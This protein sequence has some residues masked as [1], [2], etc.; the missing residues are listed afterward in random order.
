MPQLT[1]PARALTRSAFAL[2]FLLLSVAESRATVNTEAMRGLAPDAG[3]SGFTEGSL[4]LK[5]GNEDLW[6]TGLGL[7][8]QHAE[9]F[10]EAGASHGAPSGPVT[11]D[12][13]NRAARLR[14]SWLLVSQLNVGKKNGESFLNN[15]FSHA[16]WTRM[17]IPSAGSELFAQHQFNK[18]LRLDTRFLVGTNARLIVLNGSGAFL[19]AGS[20]Y[21]LELESLN[22]DEISDDLFHRWNNYLSLK[23]TVGG[24]AQLSS[25]LYLQPRFD[26]L[27]DFRSLSENELEVK[28]VGN[29]SL[30][31]VM[32]FAYDSRP[33]SGVGRQDAEVLQKLRYSF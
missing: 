19:A 32:K 9:F 22:G 21:M 1:T 18:F 27:A 24:S 12:P 17:W 8:L 15:G 13:K 20:G 16:R 31:T 3:W 30:A 7:R 29:L 10:P 25:T 26:A 14:E 11:P 28:L 33:P 6:Q 4:L 2:S 23:I 5:T